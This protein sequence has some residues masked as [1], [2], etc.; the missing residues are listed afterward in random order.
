M[1]VCVCAACACAGACVCVSEGIN[2]QWCNID[3]VRLV[4]QALWPFPACSC[5]L[6]H[7]L[8]IKYMGIV[9]LTRMH[10]CQR[11]LR[12]HGTSYRRITHKQSISVIKVS[13]KCVATH[14]KEG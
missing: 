2:N 11:R 1:C 6:R 3:H 14:L 12:Q 9:L 13:G 7:L 5:L 8:S 10:A 4:K